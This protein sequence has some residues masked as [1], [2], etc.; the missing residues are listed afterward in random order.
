[1]VEIK[2]PPN[3]LLIVCGIYLNVVDNDNKCD[4]TITDSYWANK[5]TSLTVFNISMKN[6]KNHT[7]WVPIVH[8]EKQHNMFSNLCNF[9]SSLKNV[10]K[11]T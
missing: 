11:R 1:M 3:H 6:C 4:I 9:R 8:V 7:M 5:S 2:K 10:L